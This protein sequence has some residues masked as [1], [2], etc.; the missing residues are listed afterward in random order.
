MA[1]TKYLFKSRQEA[2]AKWKEQEQ[3][4]FRINLALAYVLRTAKIPDDHCPK[5]G[6]HWFRGTWYDVA[7]IGPRR[8]D[9]GLVLTVFHNN[10][11]KDANKTLIPS[12]TVVDQAAALEALANYRRHGVGGDDGRELYALLNKALSVPEV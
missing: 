8:A 7:R 3:E 5:Y 10:R 4:S 6:V 11:G 9:G 2:E 1:R 12:T